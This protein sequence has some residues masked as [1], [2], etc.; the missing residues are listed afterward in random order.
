[1]LLR[2]ACVLLLALLTLTG[3]AL[4]GCTGGPT[5][6]SASEL[7]F[8]ARNTFDHADSLHVVLTSQDAPPTGTEL[9]GGE[10][11]LARPASFRGTLQLLATGA[12]LDLPVVSVDGTVY[13]QLPSTTG[14]SVVEPAQLGFRD[15]GA[16]LEPDTGISR[17]LGSVRDAELG[18]LRRLDGEVVRDVTAQLRGDLVEQ[19]LPS[20]DPGRPVE[21][22]LSIATETSE[23]RRMELTGPFF[24]QAY[25]TY[26]LE[27][28]DYGVDVEITPPPTAGPTQ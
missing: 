10:G 4:T 16:L 12:M 18:E 15:P 9:L 11:D 7:L 17:L 23:L 25:A 2:R 22:R 14:Y 26:V 24:T 13:A 27:L 3:P 28:S 6:A 5:T 1:M 21:A 19:L 20:E 8:R